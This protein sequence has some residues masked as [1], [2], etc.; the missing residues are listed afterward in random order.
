MHASK[1]VEQILERSMQGVQ[2]SLRK[3]QAYRRQTPAN[4]KLGKAHPRSPVAAHIKTFDSAL[5]A[6]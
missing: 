1:P 3:K 6:W 4:K 5:L 2:I